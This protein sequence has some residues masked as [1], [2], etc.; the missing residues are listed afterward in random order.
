MKKIPFFSF[1]IVIAFAVRAQENNV[2]A[3]RAVSLNGV[4]DYVDLGDRYDDIQL[5]VTISAWIRLSSAV[6][7]WAPVFVSQDNANLYNGF[8]LIVQPGLVGIG[9]G[10]GEGENLPLYRRSK[11]AIVNDISDRWVHV[12]GVIRDKL[13]M[14]IYVNGMDVGGIYSGTSNLPMSATSTDVAK[15]GRWHSN[16]LTF[17]FRGFIDEVRLWNRSLSQSEV[18]ELLCRKVNGS[19][20]GLVGNWSFNEIAG[21]AILDKTPSE[22]EGVLVGGQRVWSGAPIGDGSKYLYTS[23]WAQANLS[24]VIGEDSLT[25]TNITG[26]PHGI[27]VYWVLEPPSQT[28]GLPDDCT[29]DSYF[30]VFADVNQAETKYDIHYHTDPPLEYDL[31][32]YERADNS[33]P[34]WNERSYA[35]AVTG[36]LISIGES[37]RGEYIRSRSLKVDLGDDIVLCDQDDVLLA[38]APINSEAT[39]TWS[40][41][42]TTPTLVVTASGSYA[43]TVQSQCGTAADEIQVELRHS[44][45]AFDLHSDVDNLCSADEIV[46]IPSEDLSSYPIRWSDGSDT[47]FLAVTMPG[48]YTLTASNQCGERSASAAIGYTPLDSVFI[49]NVITPGSDDRNQTFEIRDVKGP[50]RLAIYNRWGTIVYRSRDYQ[51]DWDGGDLPAGVYYYSVTGSCVGDRKGSLSILRQ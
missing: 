13:D 19:E 26:D 14:D 40:T 10:D 37:Y 4:T 45:P 3:G 11:T 30:G 25:A 49:P 29:A 47:P 35:D 8:W 21:S 41:G 9:Y 31:I 34:N 24:A 27:Y 2:G 42:A 12:T 51:G 20:T 15:I 46:L 5:P 22:S 39:I 18:R 6:T 32:L 33:I 17:H 7:D 43:V 1:L 48:T 44:P 50:L 23:S 28:S 16:G 36:G 38:P